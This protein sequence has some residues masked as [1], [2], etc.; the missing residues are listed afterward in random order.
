MMTTSPLGGS[1]TSRAASRCTGSWVPT[2]HIYIRCP[3]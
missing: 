2:G 3:L 1:D